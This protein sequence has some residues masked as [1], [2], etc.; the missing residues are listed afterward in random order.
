MKD[1]R[2]YVEQMLDAASKIVE[3][4]ADVRPAA[5]AANREKQSAVILQLAIIGEN[6]K[7]LSDG[8]KNRVPLPWKQIA[9]FRDRAIHDYLS[10]D[11]DE[12]WKTVESDIPALVAALKPEISS[13]S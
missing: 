5:F 4:T 1:D 12:V 9:G 13:P 8:F 2:L 6:A 10:L 7:R 11:L 3:F